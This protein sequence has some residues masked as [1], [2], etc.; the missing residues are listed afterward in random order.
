VRTGPCDACRL[1]DQ[2]I[3]YYGIDAFVSFEVGRMLLN[4]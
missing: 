4:Y 2:Q 3:K 1:S